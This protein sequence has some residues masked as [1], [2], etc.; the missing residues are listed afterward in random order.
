MSVVLAAVL[1]S[2]DGIFLRPQLYSLP[3][4]LVVFLEHALGTIV[5]ARFLIKGRKH[6]KKLPKLHRGALLRVAIFGGILGTLFIT[7]A[8]FLAI[9]GSVTFATV[10]LLQKLQPLFALAMAAILLR[11]RLAKSFYLRAGVAI[12]AAYILAFGFTLDVGAINR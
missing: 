7:K 8:F 9:D 10:I 5:F 11:E 4:A 1:R 6:I 12:I 3:P 2:L